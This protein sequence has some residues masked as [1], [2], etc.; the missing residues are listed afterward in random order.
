MLLSATCTGHV[1]K[2]INLTT[3]SINASVNGAQKQIDEN[4]AEKTKFKFLLSSLLS[5]SCI[6]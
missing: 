4:V 5:N 1:L 3:R 6:K 2:F